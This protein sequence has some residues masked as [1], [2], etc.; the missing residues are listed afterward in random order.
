MRCQPSDASL[1]GAAN[2]TLGGSGSL[3]ATLTR[4]QSHKTAPQPANNAPTAAAPC[5]RP[6]RKDSMYRLASGAVAGLRTVKLWKLW[7]PSYC[8]RGEMYSVPIST[9]GSSMA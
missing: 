8:I 7:V 3:H 6:H 4:Q 9:A 1:A 2:R 5:L